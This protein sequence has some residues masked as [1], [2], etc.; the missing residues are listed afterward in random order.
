MSPL[1][2]KNKNTLVT[3]LSSYWG[4]S[5]THPIQGSLLEYYIPSK[6]VTSENGRFRKLEVWKSSR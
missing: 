5:L 3:T 1:K 6:K 4:H 2:I